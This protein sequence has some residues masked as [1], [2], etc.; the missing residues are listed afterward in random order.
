MWYYIPAMR[1]ALLSD[2]HANMEAFTAV[3]DDIRR[4]G[5]VDEYWCLGDI[6]D[7]GPDPSACIQLLRQLP[8]ICVAG[9]H[10]MVAIGKAD[11]N[12][13]NP[14]AALTIGWTQQQISQDDIEY[15]DDL[16]QV[17]ERGNF[18]MVHGS[19]RQPLWEYLLS[20]GSAEESFNYF[21]TKYCLVGHSHKPLMFRQKEDGGCFSIQLSE[22]IGQVLGDKRAIFNPGSIG[23]PRDGDPRAS[24]AIYDDESKVVR[25]C[26]VAY[27]INA[28]QQKMVK[29]NLPVKLMVRLEQGL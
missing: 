21:S 23:Q 6:I 4:R 13:F 26:R 10:D 29:A 17:I 2:I 28:T 5:G 1:Y 15:L 8:H 9:N 25:L 14:D 27:D 3:L 20:S 7:Y 11:V 12:R 16:P 18:T 19:P 24:Y 22:S